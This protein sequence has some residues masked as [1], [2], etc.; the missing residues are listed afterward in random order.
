MPSL[1]QQ[2]GKYYLQYYSKDRRPKQK[3]VALQVRVKRDA[4]KI[5]QKLERDYTLGTFDPWTDDP[6]TYDRVILKPE[7]LREARKAFL[8]TKASKA[9]RTVENYTNF[10]GRFADF[11]GP[12]KLISSVEAQDIEAWLD[13]TDA[14]TVSRHTYVR[15]LRVWFRW[16]KKEE[17]TER[18]A[19]DGVRLKRMPKKFDRYLSEEEVE[20]IVNVIRTE[21]LSAFWL[22]DLVQLAV[23]TGLRRSEL[24]NL[25]WEHI[26][27][28]AGFLIVA[29]TDTFTT[30]SGAERKVPLSNTA[31]KVLERRANGEKADGCPYVFSHEDGQFDPDYI[32]RAFKRYARKAG[33]GDVHLHHLR[34]TACSWLAERGVPIE[35]IRRFAGHSTIAVTER[36]MHLADDVYANKINAAFNGG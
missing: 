22:A 24:A 30:K 25:R 31:R 17:L 7:T 36:Y 6:L 21:A 16:A 14:G 15:Y 20:R 28:D 18:V 13:S 29:N 3:R 32:S 26:N 9:A 27:L 23:Q 4:E 5:R 19:T 12:D 33:I 34:H 1:I 35:A 8:E 11:H 10:T 2:H